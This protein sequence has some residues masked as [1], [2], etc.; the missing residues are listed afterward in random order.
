MPTYI[1][2][3]AYDGTDFYGWQSQPDRV[4]VIR[5]LTRT[6]YG[7]FKKRIHITGAS[8]TDAGVHALGQ[9]ASFST[10]LLLDPTVMAR[11]WNSALPSSILIRKIRRQEEPFAP[12]AG[13]SQ[14]IYYYHFFLKRPSPFIAR[15]G[16]FISHQLDLEK[17]SRCLNIFKGTHDFRSFCTGY[18]K[19]NTVRVIDHISLSAL[20]RYGCYRITIKGAGFLRYMIR[21]IVGACFDVTARAELTEEALLCSLAQKNPI[22]KYRTAPANGLMLVAIRYK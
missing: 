5:T 2:T 16:H 7:V 6:F 9:I 10:D 22:Q 8:R 15:Y 4:T 12:R 11:V 3:V 1:V 21:R 14:K 20:D 19:E 17:L 18:E 13:V